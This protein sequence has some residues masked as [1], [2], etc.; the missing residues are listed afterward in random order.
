MIHTVLAHPKFKKL[1]R[2]LKLTHYA[3]VGV[4]E[5]IWLI[6]KQVYHDGA[7]G[8][9]TNEDIAA[10]I[11]YEGDHDELISALVDCG[12]LDLCPEK[13][14]VIH[15]WL[16]HC[17]KYVKGILARKKQASQSKVRPQG[18]DLK[19]ATPKV[20]PQGSD[21]HNITQHN[22]TLS[23]ASNSP[24]LRGGESESP[25]VGN[26]PGGPSR[27]EAVEIVPLLTFPCRGKEKEWHL[28]QEFVDHMESAYPGLLI[29]AEFK[30]ALGWV[31]SN[32]NNMKTATGMKRFLNGWLS[33]AANSQAK[34]S[35]SNGKTLSPEAQ[36]TNDLYEATKKMILAKPSNS[37]PIAGPN[38]GLGFF[39][40]AKT[41]NPT[42]EPPKLITD[43]NKSHSDDEPENELNW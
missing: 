38:L 26:G 11:E 42:T 23:Y 30:R 21:Q 19:G 6:G 25:L 14:L 39:K 13:R 27:P 9:M 1:K 43:E 41:P 12:W 5:S 17:P 8:D 7:I 18:C 2:R 10:H 31:V 4:L 29:I 36:K 33:R 20:P 28:H 34:L 35:H 15:D 16:D 3:T 24:P 32:T 37:I 22:I 40:T